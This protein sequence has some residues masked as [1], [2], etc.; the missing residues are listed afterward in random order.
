MLFLGFIVR[1][2]KGTVSV[3]MVER[4]WVGISEEEVVAKKKKKN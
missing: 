2:V 1:S 4:A 3:F